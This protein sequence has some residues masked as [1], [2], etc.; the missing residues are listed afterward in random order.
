VSVGPVTLE[1]GD[2]L[3]DVVVAYETWGRLAPDAANAVLVEHALT[4]DA[5]VEGPA[6]LGQ[7]SPGWWPGLIG[8]GASLDTDTWFV[9]CANVLGGCQGTTGPSSIAPDGRC[10]GSRFPRLT[11]RDQVAVEAR[12]AD[13]LGI[14]SWASVV[15]GSMGGMRVLEWSVSHPSRVRS[16]VAIACGA[17]ATAEQ[18]ATQSAQV[19]AIVSDPRWRGGDY[20]AAG[21]GDGPHV[22]LG[23]A[24][25]FAHLT[26][27][28]EAELRVRFG[29][30]PQPGE[31]PRRGGR[32]AVSSYLDHHADK[33]ARRFDAGS[34]VA[35]TNAM[36]TH[37]VGRG[38]GGVAA[39]LSAVTAPVVVAGIDTD[40]LFPLYLQRELCQ[41]MPTSDGPHV[42]CSPHGHDGFLLE[43]DQVGVLVQRAL[44]AVR[45]AGRLLQPVADGR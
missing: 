37:D 3:C 9:V 24:R 7:V 22:G 23:V 31:D 17:A 41:A 18:I 34:Y 5:H 44:A 16:A 15:G 1:S 26:Y 12:L 39:A 13:A 35:L 30:R 14:R 43:T 21:P 29:S 40:R 33:L 45:P 4:G 32:F 28:S 38:R 25:R 2:T 6:G 36:S 20:H 42:V 19:Q 8:P 27:R 10:Y 11:V